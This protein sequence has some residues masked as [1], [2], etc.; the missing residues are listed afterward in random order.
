MS[1]A[2]LVTARGRGLIGD[3][4]TIDK[5]LELAE[6]APPGRYRLGKLHYDPARGTSGPGSGARS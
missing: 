3:A 4:D 2:F 6:A 1:V 5:V